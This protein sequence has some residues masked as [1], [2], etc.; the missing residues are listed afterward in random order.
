MWADIC[1]TNGEAITNDL[2]QLQ[3][4]LGE[5]IVAIENHDRQTV[6][7]YFAASKQLRDKLLLDAS[8]KFDPN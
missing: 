5:V 2:R 7:D 6:H 4:I 8:K 3:N 1:M